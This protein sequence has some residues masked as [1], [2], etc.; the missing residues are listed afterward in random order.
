[1]KMCQKLNATHSVISNEEENAAYSRFIANKLSTN[2]EVQDICSYVNEGSNY[3]PTFILAQHKE[4]GPLE[5]SPV[6]DPYNGK[7]INYV[8]WFT[9]WPNGNYINK[10]SFWTAFKYNDGDSKF[11]HRYSNEPYC[12]GNGVDLPVLR[13]RG[14]C[15]NSQFD[16]NYVLAQNSEDIFSK[17][18]GAQILPSTKTKIYGLLFPTGIQNETSILKLLLWDIVV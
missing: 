11:I 6:K 9:G 8:N 16:K 14:F 1:M 18:T 17:K 5:A 10:G 3:G 4:E 12:D 7:T 2:A 15:Q 13:M